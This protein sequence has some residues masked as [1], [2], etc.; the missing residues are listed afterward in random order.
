MRLKR[1]LLPTSSAALLLTAWWAWAQQQPADAVLKA[2]AERVAVI[3]R[4]V[5]AVVA[6]FAPG[7]KNGG[8][9]VVIT[10]DGYALTNFH[11]V[12]A[13]GPLMKCG[14]ADGVL[15]DAVL[16]GEDKVGDVALIRLYPKKEGQD[17]PFAPLGDSDLVRE[18][19]WSVAAGNPFLL[20]RDFRPTVTFGLVSGVHRYQYPA[21]SFLEYPDCIQIDTSINPGNS[22][23]PLYNM[24]GELI[25]INGRGSFDKRG[26]V[27]SGVGYAISINQIKNFMGH[28]RAGLECD[29][30][31]LGARVTTQTDKYGLGQ[32]TVTSILDDS[33]AA[34]RG[35]DIDD[36]LVSFDG[37]PM[38]SV[39]Q[40]FNVLGVFP[41]GW[42]VPLEYR[43]KEVR[44]EVLVRLMGKT[45]Q[46][47][48]DPLQPGGPPQPQPGPIPKPGGKKPFP[49]APQGPPSPLTKFF[50]PKQPAVANMYFNN[51]ERDRLLVAFKKH[52]DFSALTSTWTIAGAARYKALAVKPGQDT[53]AVTFSV[54]DL[55]DGDKTYPTA[56]MTTEGS[57]WSLKVLES[58]DQ[59]VLKQP[60]SSGGLLS[61]MYLYQLL[62]TK[63]QQ[64]FEDEF[65]H[66][67]YEPF[68]PPA[69][70]DKA[71]ASLKDLRVDCEVLRTRTAQYQAKWYFDRRDLKLLGFEVR[72]TDNE[73][74]CEVYLS[75]YQTV[76]GRELPRR[77]QVIHGNAPYG[78]FHL[79]GFR[80]GEA[81]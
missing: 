11:V 30:A 29:H 28:L 50:Q 53:K 31:S 56:Q 74:P 41:R 71:P 42:R 58:T 15:Y 45:A 14:L 1:F 46:V 64:G 51:L 18:G 75:D 66:G 47:L 21:G 27:N 72:L 67:G 65:I 33:D 7:G 10:K 8:S 6:V 26:R 32:M 3:Q 38:G 5:P 63:G 49:P 60:P 36:E 69:T 35:L 25:G 22:G 44:K 55:K 37:R 19:D 40:Y 13:T 79:K 52:G 39:N 4:I 20:A 17:F 76:D 2:E 78:V 57:T 34:R 70:T 59:A 54:G 12:Q 61:A 77:M 73:D 23:G 43:R 9:G 68:Y 80:F 81:K 48:L 24:K 62:L 16:V